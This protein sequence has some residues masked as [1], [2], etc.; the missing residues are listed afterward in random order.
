MA[1]FGKKQ[2]RVPSW[3]SGMPDRESFDAWT[4]LVLQVFESADVE[5]SA[6]DIQTG[7]VQFADNEIA[8]HELV[9]RCAAEEDHDKWPDI[10]KEELTGLL[11][12][13][14]AQG[15]SGTPH[16]REDTNRV[17]AVVRIWEQMLPV[18]RG[19]NYEQPLGE[20]LEES[21]CGE[22]VG[23]G[24][25]LNESREI[26]Y[27]EIELKLDD[28][29]DTLMSVA[30]LLCEH[31]VPKNSRIVV[32]HPEEEVELVF[33]MTEGVCFTLPTAPSEDAVDALIERIRAALVPEPLDYRGAQVVRDTELMLQ[34]YGLD[35]E[36]LWSEIMPILAAES[37]CQGGRAVVRCGHEAGL[38]RQ[39]TLAN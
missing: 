34:F 5:V 30:D 3:A 32:F 17:E 33:G 14:D 29:E 36:E 23:G 12:S 15:G 8:L 39:T 37:F 24:T 31:G 10:V 11:D 4:Q 16:L 22:V 18:S 1:W 13:S 7:T 27:I 20:L 21:G 19:L 28:S 38:P 25:Q 6:G 2:K 9:E 35:A 26:E